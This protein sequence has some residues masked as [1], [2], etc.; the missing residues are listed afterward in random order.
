[1]SSN[2]NTMSVECWLICSAMEESLVNTSGQSM[3]NDLYHGKMTNTIQCQLCGEVS[4]RDEDF[5]DLCVSVSGSSRLEDSLERMFV[6][7][8]VL[9]T[10]NRYRCGMCDQLSDAVKYTRLRHVPPVLTISL[11]R[12]NYDPVKMER[13]KETGQFEFPLRLDMSRY[14]DCAPRTDTGWITVTKSSKCT[15]NGERYVRNGLE[16]GD[17][18]GLNCV[19]SPPTQME[20]SHTYELF[21]VVVHRGGAHGGHYHALIRDLAGRGSWSEPVRA[22]STDPPNE[23][24]TDTPPLPTGDLNSHR[25]L[26][27]SILLESGIISLGKLSERISSVAGESWWKGYRMTRGA[28]GTFLTNNSDLFVYNSANDVVSLVPD[29][30]PSESE[31]VPANGLECGTVSSVNSR[32]PVVCMKQPYLPECMENGPDISSPASVIAYILTHSGGS[33]G[34]SM[35][36]LCLKILELTGDSWRKRYKP[37]HGSLVKFL[38][39]HSD[40]FEH[41]VSGGWVTLLARPASR[42]NR[43]NCG[44]SPTNVVQHPDVSST[45][46]ETLPRSKRNQKSK[47]KPSVQES[48]STPHEEMIKNNETLPEESRPEPGYCWF[49]FDDS[50]IR[51]IHTEEIEQQFEGKECAYMLFYR[52][53]QNTSEDLTSKPVEIPDWLI[54]EIMAEDQKLEDERAEYDEFVNMLK[55]EIHFGNS[56]E[57]CD[58]VLRPR[59]G[60]CFYVEHTVNVRHDVNHLLRDVSELGGEL[61]DLCHMIHIAKS[62]P[63]GGLHLYQELTASPASSLK[64]FGVGQSTKLFVWNGREIDGVAILVGFE[65]EPIT[66]QF[67]LETSPEIFTVTVAKNMTVGALKSVITSRLQ[68]TAADAPIHLYRTNNSGD[69]QPL[70]GDLNSTITEAGL[71]TR[72][73]LFVLTSVPPTTMSKNDPISLQ[74]R[75]ETSPEIFTVTVARNTTVGALKS[76]ITSKVHL[77]RADAPIRLFRTNISGDPQPL[78]GDLNRTI[79]EAGLRTRDR[80]FVL[81]S[82]PPTTMSKNDPISL[83]FG[84]ETSSEISTITVAKNT[85]VLAL[86]ALIASRLNLTGLDPIHLC[87]TKKKGGK[88]EPLVGDLDRTVTEAGLQARDRLFVRHS[89][90]PTSTN[91]RQS[92]GRGTH[93]KFCQNGPQKHITVHAESHVGDNVVTVTVEADPAASVEELKVLI[94][95]SADVPIEQLSEVRVRVRLDELGIGGVGPPLY[96][97]VDLA[98]AGLLDGVSVVLECGRSPQDTEVVLTVSVSASSELELTVDRD[99][100]VHQL[101]HEVLLRAAVSGTEWHLCRS[102]WFGDSAAVLREP[103]QTIGVAGLSHGDH[104]FLRPGC[105]PPPGFLKI[106]VHLESSPAR[107]CWW[108]PVRYMT[109]AVSQSPV[110]S[111]V[112]SKQSTLLELKY[113]IMTL[114]QD[115]EVPSPQFMRLRILTASLRPTTILRGHTE[116]LNRLKVSD[117]FSNLIVTVTEKIGCS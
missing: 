108:D 79:T 3:I 67:Q 58:G 95:T 35:N 5:F 36:D 26:I 55:V 52:V 54:S 6:E 105:P 73:S 110:G 15:F 27:T 29:F 28:L 11:L 98:A 32:D 100:A 99:M 97:A 14:R 87:W 85:T 24:S 42:N 117:I 2:A 20:L 41:D 18:L 19:E 43:N 61:V 89:K 31:G 30:R 111:V 69:P 115:Y 48:V 8:E 12:F 40:L 22:D 59:I 25:S 76:L 68:L 109:E 13:Y 91:T 94:M 33:A 53:V 66:L 103:N 57:C 78:S 75:L 86:K 96:E 46:T 37:R 77:T 101:L 74:F 7:P 44:D 64:S 81:T 1:M 49:D 34:M 17:N 47:S 70:S 88:P 84:L 106:F 50:V 10:S 102:D 83:R 93:A 45:V 16:C 107:P 71:R 104:L 65:N 21:S 72:D 23:T 82:V 112:I 38:S 63:S 4:E 114:L 116:T 56:Y 113:Q 39:D 51:P 60:A 62:L 9:D 90:T 80:L 92:S